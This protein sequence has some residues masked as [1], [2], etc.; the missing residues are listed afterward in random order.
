M[1][2]IRDVGECFTL[3]VQ[4]MLT[5]WRSD[6]WRCGVISWARWIPECLNRIR[7]SDDGAIGQAIRASGSVR[8]QWSIAIWSLYDLPPG[9]AEN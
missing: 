2:R 1:W 6:T 4:M 8:M 3:M 7:L 5:W 9:S